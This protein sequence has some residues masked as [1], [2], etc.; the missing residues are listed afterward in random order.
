[1]KDTRLQADGTIRRR[2]V[3]ESGHKFS[4][5]E[6]MTNVM[7]LIESRRKSV[8]AWKARNPEKVKALNHRRKRRQEARNESVATGRPIEEIYQLWGVA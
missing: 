4:T 8:R 1:M 5:W 6:T 2:R 7:A 3:C